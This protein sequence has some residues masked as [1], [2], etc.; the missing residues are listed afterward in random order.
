MPIRS[1]T[2]GYHVASEIQQHIR[3][4]RSYRDHAIL[5]RT[6]AQ[7]RVI[8]EIFIKSDI[9]YQIV[10]GISFYERKEIKD[11]LAYLRLVSNPDDDISFLRIVNVP[12]RGIGDSHVWM[13][14]AAACSA[15]EASRSSRAWTSWMRS[16]SARPTA[17]CA[18]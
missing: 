12:K 16:R 14:L 9:P 3:D 10:G 4:G 17:E 2:E 5:Y 7:S 11:L 13:K 15:A 18:L 8:E 6:N 1:M